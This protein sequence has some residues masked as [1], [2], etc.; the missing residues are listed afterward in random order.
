MLWLDKHRPLQLHQMDFHGPLSGRLSQLAS[1]SEVPHMIFYGPP[2][3]G[4]KTRIMAMLRKMYG[5][6]VSKM[7]MEELEVCIIDYR[8]V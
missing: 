2:G 4:K 1:E 8:R 5:S 6:G 7:K 3:S